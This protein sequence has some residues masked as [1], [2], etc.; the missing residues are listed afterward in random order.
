[1]RVRLMLDRILTLFRSGAL[2]PLPA[3]VFPMEQIVGAYRTMQQAGHI[4]KI[5]AT[6]PPW[7]GDRA[8]D[9]P[10]AFRPDAT[11]LITGAFGGIGMGLTQWLFDRGARHLALAGRREPSATAAAR[12]ADLEAAGAS[13]RVITC[14]VASEDQV[15]QLFTRD[16]AQMLPL[17]G[18][19]HLAGALD[20]GALIHQS[21][22]RFE[23]VFA[24]KVLGAWNLHRWT[25]TTPL[26]CFVLFSSWSSFLGSPGQANHSAANAFLDALAWQRRAAGRPA[27]SINWGAWAEIGAATKGEAAEHLRRRGI[28]SFSPT[29]GFR[30]LGHLMSQGTVQAAFTPFDIARWRQSTPA[31]TRCSWFELLDV[32]TEAPPGSQTDENQAGPE[33][34]LDR[35]RQA[36][37][38]E[39]RRQRMQDFLKAQVAQTLRQ[40]IA[41]IDPH[42]PFKSYGMDSLT[43]L[44]FRNRIEAAT[45]ATFSATLVFNYPNIHQL[46]TFLLEKLQDHPPHSSE[47]PTVEPGS[48]SAADEL[49]A[50]LD[51]V[52]KLSDEDARKLLND[53]H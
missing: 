41:R 32:A 8:I 18:V 11:Y 37:S 31:A 42:K 24:P 9:H 43:A 3:K 19:F 46:E 33:S 40:P 16:L 35:L 34:L 38:E 49:S 36:S 5:V 53:E 2:K 52:E 22:A 50:L 14:D 45:G 28:G 1:M 13:I 29:M 44:E 26:D 39:E 17:R 48:D 23:T 21:W 27:L 6:L 10:E 51:E 20:D 47:A 30:A 25:A 12:I 15:E 4:G 7:C